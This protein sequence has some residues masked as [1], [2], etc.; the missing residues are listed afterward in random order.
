MESRPKIEVLVIVP[1]GLS[2][3]W[4]KNPNAGPMPAKDAYTGSPFK[5]NRL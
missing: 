3:I 2:K 1:C 4:D 5:V